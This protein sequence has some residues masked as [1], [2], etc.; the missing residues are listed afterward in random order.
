VLYPIFIYRAINEGI[1][2][3][4][5]PLFFQKLWVF[6]KIAP[7]DILKIAK[8][9]RIKLREDEVSHY[10]HEITSI[11][12]WIEQLEDVDVSHIALNDLI[13]KEHMNEREDNVTDGDKVLDVLK[14]A[15][16]ANFDMFAVPKMVE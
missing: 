6:M 14:N 3:R 12:S 4:G 1:Y 10:S 8:L 16:K 2:W 15:P 9:A 7:E 11:M 5:L 13:P